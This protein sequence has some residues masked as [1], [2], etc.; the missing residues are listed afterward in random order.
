MSL[1][2]GYNQVITF[3]LIP[4]TPPLTQVCKS[5]L[6][7]LVSTAEGSLGPTASESQLYCE[8]CM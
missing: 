3:Q 8:P 5:V 7:G 2:P 1:P 6:A 4:A